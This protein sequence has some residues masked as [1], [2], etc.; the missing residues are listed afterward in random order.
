MYWR[1]PIQ[2]LRGDAQ[3][4]PTAVDVGL[5]VVVVQADHE[6]PVPGKLIVVPVVASL[7]F[8]IRVPESAAAA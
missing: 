3:L 2:S 6:V 8:M 7:S 1:A 4:C 5:V